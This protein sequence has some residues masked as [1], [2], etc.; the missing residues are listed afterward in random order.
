MA[1]EDSTRPWGRY[2]ILQESAHHKV[3]C[4]YVDPGARLSYQ[5]HQ[6]RREHWFIVSG[7][8]TVVI[9]GQSFTKVAGETVEVDVGQLHRI[10]NSGSQELVFVEI[11]TGTYFGEDDI[12][13]IQ[14]DY[15][16]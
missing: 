11:Q 16:R 6:K 14:D 4:I 7:E 13:R 2:E 10:G 8:A 5:R 1:D 9:D 3:K 12:E 15:A